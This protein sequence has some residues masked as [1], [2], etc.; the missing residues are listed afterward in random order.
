MNKRWPCEESTLDMNVEFWTVRFWITNPSAAKLIDPL[1]YAD[2]ISEAVS[3][4]HSI[5]EIA[6]G[7]ANLAVDRGLPLAAVQVKVKGADIGHMIYLIEF[8]E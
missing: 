1:V 2:L 5:S 7:I 6:D 4:W 3:V 8:N